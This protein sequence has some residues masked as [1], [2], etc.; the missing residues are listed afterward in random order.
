MRKL[1]DEAVGQLLATKDTDA[2]FDGNPD[3]GHSLLGVISRVLDKVRPGTR[4]T[5]G[6]LA[7]G[8]VIE[9][10]IVDGFTDG[11]Y[12]EKPW[13]I[14]DA[15]TDVSLEMM[16]AERD[17]LDREISQLSESSRA[18][19]VLPDGDRW[20]LYACPAVMGE[21]YRGGHINADGTGYSTLAGAQFA[22]AEA[23]A[24]VDRKGGLDGC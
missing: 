11:A 3:W 20:N 6:A 5:V 2:C 19:Q 22:L 15:L 1:T 13:G 8:R 16:R 10:Q 14:R 23:L 12:G 7:D 17:R 18:L 4:M 9:I 24:L 21:P